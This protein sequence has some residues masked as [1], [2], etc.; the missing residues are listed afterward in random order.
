[1]SEIHRPS[2]ERQ[3]DDSN[4]ESLETKKLRYRNEYKSPL[5]DHYI[6]S[7]VT[8][9]LH[10]VL[11]GDL[12]KDGRYKV[13]NMVG[14][15]SFSNVWAARDTH[16]QDNQNNND[17][18]CLKILKAS[19]SQGEVG[20]LKIMQYIEANSATT[21]PGRKYLP[22]LLDHF[23][24]DGPNGRHLCIV[25]NIL[26]SN[27]WKVRSEAHFSEKLS[28]ELS[29]HISRQLILAVDFLHSIG[30][31]HGD[32]NEG[33][34][35]FKIPRIERV[36]F[37]ETFQAKVKRRDGGPLEKGI[38]EI[39]VDP[40]EPLRYAE[41]DELSDIQLI[42]FSSAFLEAHP[43]ASVATPVDLAPPEVIFKQP[44]TKAVDIWNLGCVTYRYSTGQEP[45]SIILSRDNR[46]LIPQIYKLLGDAC[47]PWMLKAW[48]DAS[49]KK[50]WNDL[51]PPNMVSW[52]HSKRLAEKL[53]SDYYFSVALR[54]S[55]EYYIDSDDDAST[56]MTD[57][58]NEGSVHL[59]EED[60]EDSEMAEG[61]VEEDCPEKEGPEEH[62]P[63][64]VQ[65]ASKGDHGY[66]A[67]LELVKAAEAYPRDHAD[68]RE[69]L[70]LATSYLSKMI[71]AD[72][73]KRATTSEL[74][75]HPFVKDI[76]YDPHVRSSV[77]PFTPQNSIISPLIRPFAAVEGMI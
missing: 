5:E 7:Y 29:R 1:M 61:D 41:T 75:L 8:G 16:A 43:A 72:P 45:F 3:E 65:Q 60:L 69:F 48:I 68:K 11:M 19:C 66:Q 53:P 25:M 52:D 31:V 21:H 28:H 50:V 39:V 9:G 77:R 10:P 26:G 2:N 14:V 15:G 36:C 46:E 24:H 62:H 20:E 71:V 56:T 51:P 76:G 17:V 70:E 35:A 74:I 4:V 73:E 38:P 64:V 55:C 40:L 47:A 54:G 6:P 23:Y 27:V 33:N 37:D 32:I 49:V 63:E 59:E 30:V 13:V 18:V 34:V 12:F 58:H 22:R 44:L 57:T 67:Y 42:D